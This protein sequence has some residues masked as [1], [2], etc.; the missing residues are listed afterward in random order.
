VFVE[1]VVIKSVVLD[2]YFTIYCDIQ[3]CLGLNLEAVGS[4]QTHSTTSVH[5]ALAQR[6]ITRIFTAMKISGFPKLNHPEMYWFVG[7]MIFKVGNLSAGKLS[8]HLRDATEV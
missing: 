7:G 4:Y 1:G 2:G 6:T 8:R 5:G 3:V